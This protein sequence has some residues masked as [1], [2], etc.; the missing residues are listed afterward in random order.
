MSE[1]RD[2]WVAAVLACAGIGLLALNLG[3]DRALL[4]VLCLVLGEIE[5]ATN[6]GQR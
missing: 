6:C 2:L 4:G 5:P 1:K 3:A